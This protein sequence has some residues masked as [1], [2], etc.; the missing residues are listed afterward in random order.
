M[1]G[2]VAEK[3]GSIL[4]DPD[5]RITVQCRAVLT[6][7]HLST[8]HL[9]AAMA[10]NHW[11]TLLMKLDQKIADGEKTL[12]MEEILIVRL[13][14]FVFNYIFFRYLGIFFKFQ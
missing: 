10:A 11:I 5:C 4:A 1:H 2:D 13:K 9:D 8:K 7:E 12:Y 3:L 6:L 14:I